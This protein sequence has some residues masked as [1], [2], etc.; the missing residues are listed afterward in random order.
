MLIDLALRA[1][2]WLAADAKPPAVD[3]LWID[4]TFK[5]IGE[6]STVTSG[7]GRVN[8]A[9]E[10][11]GGWFDAVR[12]TGAQHVRLTLNTAAGG[13]S[14]WLASAFAN[15]NDWGLVSVGVRP[16]LWRARWE[17][18]NPSAPDR[19]IWRVTVTG[20]WTTI[21]A[22]APDVGLSAVEL[23]T[24]LQALG[25]FAARSGES[26]WA[27]VMQRA[28]SQLSAESPECAYYPEMVPQ[29]SLPLDRHQLLAAATHGWI[30]G[31]MGS[32]NDSVQGDSDEYERVSSDLW[33]AL[34]RAFM[35][36]VNA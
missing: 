26:G 30:F 8:R 24:A 32:W 12:D 29:G 17:V 23:D 20:E 15:G 2:Q 34:T 27:T 6:F 35:A 13:M 28:R 4:D 5:F 33:N 22:S 1:N 7:L 25:D 19:R 3:L 36:A 16:A 14:P 21:A 31:G 10:G 9:P 18:T 11:T